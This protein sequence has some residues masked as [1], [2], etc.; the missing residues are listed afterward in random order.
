MSLL[1]TPERRAGAGGQST[2]SGQQISCPG[3]RGA[4]G[5]WGRWPRQHFGGM[6]MIIDP[7]GV[8]LVL[9]LIIVMELAAQR[10]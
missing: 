5:S 6:G 10:I 7:F 1:S 4:V 8:A 9:L 3:D 2:E